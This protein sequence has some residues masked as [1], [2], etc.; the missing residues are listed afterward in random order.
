MAEERLVREFID[1]ESVYWKNDIIINF[2]RTSVFGKIIKIPF[3]QIVIRILEEM[4]QHGFNI[5]KFGY[6]RYEVCYNIIH[7]KNTPLLIYLV[8]SN[9]EFSQFFTKHIGYI[10]GKN[11]YYSYTHMFDYML[12][13][14]DFNDRHTYPGLWNLLNCIR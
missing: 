12:E 5:N 4:G 1:N 14:Y 3:S 10:I 9:K 6:T 13:N 11:C 7:N 8:N 2:S